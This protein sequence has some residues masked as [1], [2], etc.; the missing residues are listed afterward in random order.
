M[1]FLVGIAGFSLPRE[2][3]T[4]TDSQVNYFSLCMFNLVSQCGVLYFTNIST[5]KKKKH[6]IL[7]L[8]G[9]GG[10]EGSIHEIKSVKNLVTLPLYKKGLPFPLKLHKNKTHAFQLHLASENFLHQSWHC[11]VRQTLQCAIQY[12]KRLIYWK[13]CHCYQG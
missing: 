13:I 4:K 2:C 5:H 1:C 8:R 7:L 6:F 10:Q 11:T 12:T 3:I 9:I